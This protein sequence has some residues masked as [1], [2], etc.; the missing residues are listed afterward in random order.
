MFSIRVLPPS[1]SDVDGQRLG[2]IIIGE[3]SERFICCPIERTVDE[4]EGFWRTQ[5]EQL[6][7]GEPAVALVHDPRFAWVIY[8]EGERCYVRQRLA[9]GGNFQTIGPRHTTTKDGYPISE[10]ATDISAIREFMGG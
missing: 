8:R 1:E 7:L 5:L 4:M 6:L 10:W 9:V 3:F 2:E